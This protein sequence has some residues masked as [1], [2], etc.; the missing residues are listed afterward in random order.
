MQMSF[1]KYNGLPQVI[2]K[3][4]GEPYAVTG[5]G[6]SFNQPY[7]LMNPVVNITGSVTGAFTGDVK[8]L[9]YNQGV[10]YIAVID[11]EI[12]T[13]FN[14]KYYYVM[15]YEYINHGNISLRLHLDALMT[16]RKEIQEHEVILDRSSETEDPDA[17]DN[18]YP[19]SSDVL[20][21]RIDLPSAISESERT[22]TYILVTAQ[23]GYRKVGEGVGGL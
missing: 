10:N 19:L 8:N 17:V 15:D 3:D 4:I 13:E 16:Y 6:L 23:D 21:E 14:T 5:T 2:N 9:F 22:G 11:E 18:M 1:H 20:I 12:D 7:S